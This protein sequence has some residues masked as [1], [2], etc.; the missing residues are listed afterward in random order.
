MR[1]GLAL[2]VLAASAAALEAS[3]VLL[4]DCS[5]RHLG[6]GDPDL[7]L[8]SPAV[9]AGLTAALAG[10]QPPE[11]LDGDG[12]KQVRRGARVVP[13]SCLVRTPLRHAIPSMRGNTQRCWP[14]DRV[15]H[16]QRLSALHAAIQVGALVKTG[17]FDR[18]QAVVVLNL[19]GISPGAGS[20]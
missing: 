8:G 2:L 3:H 7:R 15:P 12:A 4:H 16:P 13:S 14:C 9:A 5:Q 17:V 20:V 1:R 18:P 10:L 19:A 6:A 11:P